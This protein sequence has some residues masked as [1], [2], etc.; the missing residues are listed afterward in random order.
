MEH[1][2]EILKDLPKYKLYHKLNE[3]GDKDSYCKYCSAEKTILSPH[4]GLF[5]L[6]CLF[7]KNLITLRTVLQDVKDE[8]ERCR[9]FTFWT[10]DNIRK[11]LK[12]HSENQVKIFT[13]SSRFSFI[14]STIKILL[15]PNNCSYVSRS[16][17]SF[18]LWKK[19]KDL[20]DYI[21]N[22]TEIQNQLNAN[23][24]LCS[25]YLK[26]MSYIEAV[27]ENYSRECCKGN[28]M[29]CHFSLGSNPWCNE[30]YTLPK[31]TCGESKVLAH[32]TG[33]G[34]NEVTHQQHRIGAPSPQF[35]PARGGDSDSNDNMPLNY[36]QY[37]IKISLGLL[38]S[39][40]TFTLFYMYKFTRFGNWIHTKIL[41]A[42]KIDDNIDEEAKNF[43]EH[44][45]SCVDVN[46]YN[47]DY[48]VKYYPS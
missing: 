35:S 19:W 32:S 37:Y 42:K 40:I 48:N 28:A 20:F 16:Y 25:K 22:Y 18:E 45:P 8:N 10:H 26:Y 9:Y 4:K 24:T 34:E 38:L 2:E 11:L 13:I 43:L 30:G 36:S 5:D 21:T 12:T 33:G 7:A 44:E 23:S 1:A 47:D 6:C 17:N 39:G 29:K 3:N 14:L 15:K 27:Y 31:L 46:L 41:R